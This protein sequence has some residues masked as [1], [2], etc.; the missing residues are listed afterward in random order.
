M[1]VSNHKTVRLVIE[2]MSHE[3]PKSSCLP[4]EAPAAGGELSRPSSRA[5]NLS[6]SALYKHAQ[7]LRCSWWKAS[8]SSATH[9]RHFTQESL[10]TTCS[11]G[12]DEGRNLSWDDSSED[13]DD[14]MDRS[15]AHAAAQLP[16]DT[17]ASTVPSET[18]AGVNQDQLPEKIPR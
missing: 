13:S 11:S 14:E 4:Q 12:D 1:A 10:P 3:R 9:E 5:K 2:L 6:D 17:V 15:R 7:N 8:S 16:E 18:R